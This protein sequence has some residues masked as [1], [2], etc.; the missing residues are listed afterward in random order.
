MSPQ[1]SDVGRIRRERTGRNVTALGRVTE[2]LNPY[3]WMSD[4]EAMVHLELERRRVPFSW[5]YFDGEAINT[6]YLMPDFHPEFTLREYKTAIIVLGG[7]FGQLPDVLDRTALASVLMQED[8][9]KLVIFY[10][11]EIRA[12][13]AELINRQ[14]PELVS[15]AIT[16]MHR[17]NPFGVPDFMLERRQRLSG[18]ALTRAIF[19]PR[20][21]STSGT[22]KRRFVVR[23]DSDSGRR[24][25]GRRRAP[26]G[27]R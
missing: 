14:L 13:V 9:W 8:G 22:R 18:F 19:Q 16:G 20:K 25:P 1:T 7:F 17:P 15:P 6:K 4:P 27:E 5:R 2:F 10:E 11:H 3:P 24:R 21:V 23:R 12:G 26:G